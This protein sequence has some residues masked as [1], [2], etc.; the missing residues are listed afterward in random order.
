MLYE[1][2]TYNLKPGTVRDAE[3][4]FAEATDVPRGPVAP[5]AS[6]DGSALPGGTAV[7]TYGM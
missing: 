5:E 1:L 2:R 4:R 7:D 3:A 6:T